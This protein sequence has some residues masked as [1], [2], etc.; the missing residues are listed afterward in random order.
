MSSMEVRCEF[1]ESSM[2]VRWDVLV[3]WSPI[4]ISS[5]N[6]HTIIHTVFFFAF[7][8]INTN[9]IDFILFFSG[10]GFFVCVLFCTRFL[11]PGFALDCFPVFALP[12]LG[13][14]TSPVFLLIHRFNHS[15][16]YSL[17]GR[18]IHFMIFYCFC[19][20]CLW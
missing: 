1:D 19:I 14:C 9:Q 10:S 11:S 4:Q 16:T 12:S 18:L 17:H 2:R 8:L 20:R 6:Q 5:F 13:I 15:F 3:C 7:I